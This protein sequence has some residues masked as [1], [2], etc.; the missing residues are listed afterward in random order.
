MEQQTK[1]P[2]TAKRIGKI[3]LKTIVGIFFLIVI[4]FLLILTP[5]AQNFLRKKVVAYLEKKL[6]KSKG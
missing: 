3:V 6:E 5:P 4:I 1:K 2:G